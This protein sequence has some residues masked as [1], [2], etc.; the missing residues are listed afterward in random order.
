[1][2][3]YKKYAVIIVILSIIISIDSFGKIKPEHYFEIDIK[4]I[5]R[6]Q[7]RSKLLKL[8]SKYEEDDGI[9]GDGFYAGGFGFNSKCYIGAGIDNTII[10]NVKYDYMDLDQYYLD[11]IITIKR[12]YLINVLNSFTLNL[13]ECEIL[14]T[15]GVVRYRWSY[16]N[17][18]STGYAFVSITNYFSQYSS[19]PNEENITI[20]I[21]GKNRL[22]KPP[23]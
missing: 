18:N 19:K 9:D 15:D 2:N 6:N 21:R 5:S 11:I 12:K 1:M 23:H 4:T 22:T 14:I 10:E 8:G 17:D 7:I 13:G 16:E 20:L 3:K